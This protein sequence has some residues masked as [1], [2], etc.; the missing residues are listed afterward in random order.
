MMDWRGENYVRTLRPDLKSMSNEL[1]QYKVV[2]F[3]EDRS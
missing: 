3:S 2:V 1:S